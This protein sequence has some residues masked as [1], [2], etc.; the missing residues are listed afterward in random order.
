M[1][2]GEGGHDRAREGGGTLDTVGGVM[3]TRDP[4]V[5]MDICNCD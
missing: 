3:D 5:Q 2:R 4:T 1:D